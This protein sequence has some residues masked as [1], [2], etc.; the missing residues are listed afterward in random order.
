MTSSWIL[1]Y[2]TSVPFVV[3]L[4][5]S[6]SVAVFVNISQFMCLGLFSAVTFQVTG[7]A[8]TVLV[9]LG[10]WLYLKEHMGVKELTGMS[11]SVCGMVAYGIFAG[12]KKDSA[13]AP[14]TMSL[15]A[16]GVEGPTAKEQLPSLLSGAAAARRLP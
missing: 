10:S 3:C 15:G 16:A 13:S 14:R 6:C 5:M 1:D 12:K 2:E 4:A 8:K 7:H 11:L 9:L